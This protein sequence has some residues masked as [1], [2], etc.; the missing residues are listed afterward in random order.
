MRYNKVCTA[1]TLFANFLSI[2][3]KPRLEPIIYI[4]MGSE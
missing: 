4:D 2:D 1:L 3:D